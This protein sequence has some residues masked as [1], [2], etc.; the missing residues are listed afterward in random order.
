[1]AALSELSTFAEV[2]V[3]SNNPEPNW[4]RLAFSRSSVVFLKIRGRQQGRWLREHAEKQN[5]PLHQ[6]LVLA[7]N[8]EDLQMA[9]NNMAILIGAGWAEDQYVANVGLKVVSPADLPNLARLALEW[10]GR[11]WFRAEGD[12]YTV[13]ALCDASSTRNKSQEQQRFGR[14]VT[15][16][17]KQGTP[18]L[19]SILA[20]TAGSL[21]RTGLSETKD[22]LWGVYPSSSSTNDDTETLSDFAYRLRTTVSRVRLAKR[23]EPLF[24]RHR[25]SP[26]R[27]AGEGGDREDPTAEV[28]SLRLNALYRTSLIGKNVVVIDD[29]TTFGVSM[30][31]AWGFL[32]AAKVRSMAG[33]ALGKFGNRLGNYDIK[34]NSDPFMP[35]TGGKWTYQRQGWNSENQSSE[36]Q[37]TLR[38]LLLP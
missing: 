9:K 38:Q 12:N 17:V 23:G 29:F 28:E 22:L 13:D 19:N 15:G 32:R 30:G 27:S 20:L 7:A 37:D 34:I 16:A 11:T 35:V 18:T 14:A 10:N 3:V 25:H 26:K 24:H 6:V 2:A 4:F 8:S 36:N 5:I 1:V 21:I 33:I 31:V